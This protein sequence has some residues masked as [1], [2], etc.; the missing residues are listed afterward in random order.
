MALGSCL[1]DRIRALREARGWSQA[2][3]ADRAGVTRQLVGAVEAGRHTPNVRAALG[4]ARALGVSVEELFVDPADARPETVTGDAIAP[5]T[6]LV[7]ARVGDRLIGVPLAHARAPAE[8]WAVADAVASSD[9]VEWFPAAS[10]HGLVVAGC[11]PVLGL[12][13]GLVARTSS[14][15][16][17]A[18]HASTDHSVAALGAGRVHGVLVHGPA[19]GLPA[20]PVAVRRWHVARWPV[21][22]AG[23][24]RSGS[25][26]VEEIAERRLR[27]VQRAPGASSQRAFERALATAGASASVPGPVGEGHLDVARQVAEHRGWAGVTMEPAARA[28]GLGFTSL[29]VHEVE[30]WI[31]ER[32]IAQPA[33]RS[34]VE[35]LTRP[36]FLRRV[37]SLGGYDLSSTGS[38]L[39]ATPRPPRR[40][41]PQ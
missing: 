12:L 24:S 18:V 8:A 23:R 14:D 38:E 4:L 11:D 34:L 22:L 25:P 30:L 21:G 39:D 19:D 13:A 15:C 2:D 20:P 29:E 3:L 37:G 9:G 27:V 7:T 32:W 35:Q 41:G 17:L 6:P 28:F 10:A 31:D 1:V 5:G 40:R 33:A 26:S 16:V 36:E